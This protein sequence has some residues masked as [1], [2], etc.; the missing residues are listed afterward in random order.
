V[1]DNYTLWKN[2]ESGFLGEKLGYTTVRN[3]MSA[4]NIV[5]GFQIHESNFTKEYVTAENL[6]IVGY[7]QGNA[8]SDVDKIYSKAR[9]LIVPR[10]DRFIAK[11]IA[12]HNFGATMTPLQSCSGCKTYKGWVNGGVTTEFTGISYNNILGNY[13]FWENFRREI[14]IDLDGTLLQ[15]M[16]ELFEMPFSGVKGTLTPNQTINYQNEHCYQPE[17]ARNTKWDNALFCDE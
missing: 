13:I 6:L 4:D 16:R 9:G 1:Y 2:K 7:S 10:T 15:P 8:P 12:F 17:G 3:S 5:G 14:F 11:N